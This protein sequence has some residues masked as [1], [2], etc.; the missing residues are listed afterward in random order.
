MKRG[1]HLT[2]TGK[3]K[4]A[5]PKVLPLERKKPKLGRAKK[6]K[7]YNK[8][9]HEIP[10]Q[11]TDKHKQQQKDLTK[12]INGEKTQTRRRT[13]TP[14]MY[15]KT[16]D[17]IRSRIV[18]QKWHW[19]LQQHFHKFF[20]GMGERGKKFGVS[21]KQIQ[22]EKKWKS[23]NQAQYELTGTMEYQL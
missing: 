6:R 7:L 2:R 23:Q 4:C 20:C 12:L 8:R 11:N 5:T 1:G 19:R 15:R 10:Y 16:I 3:G 17:Q 14:D 22:T 9:N 13:P 18:P 21:G